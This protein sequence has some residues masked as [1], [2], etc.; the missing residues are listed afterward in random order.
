[1]S[2]TSMTGFARRDGSAGGARFAWEI[3]SVNGRGLD[4][5]IRV[6]GGFE[7]VEAKARGLAGGRLARG[8]VTI[9]LTVQR[10]GAGGRYSV[11]TA[12]LDRL[13]AIARGYD[14]EPGLAPSSIASLLSVKGVVEAG[15]ADADEDARAA[16]DGTLA[17]AFGET[18]DA[19]VDSRRREG[20]ALSEVLNGQVDTIAALAGAAERLPSRTP[21]AIR[22]RLAEQVSALLGRD[23]LDE[24]RLHQEA[25][26]LAT[27]SDIREELDRL[28]AHVSQARDL[29]AAGGAVGRRLDFLAQ[30]FNRE[31]NT[32]CSK[33]NDVALT[34]LG[35]E[36]KAV[37]DQFK[38]QVQ[39]VE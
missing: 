23:D 3:R 36:L 12:L 24:A 38:E 20:A 28:A 14:G 6:P 39:N 8:N 2:V 32:L 1:M 26:I 21:E 25:A 37:V 15:E 16:L 19:F 27:K 13:V 5:R 4:L 29:L 17:E 18:L 31:T 11:D 35:L 34:R 7:A 30:E 10:E 9:N 22:A 33:S